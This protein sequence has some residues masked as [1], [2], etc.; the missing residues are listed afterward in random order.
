M[1]FIIAEKL[2][3][4][5]YQMPSYCT[6]YHLFLEQFKLKSLNLHIHDLFVNNKT[7]YNNTPTDFR[8]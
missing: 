5:R 3:I 8:L 4:N 2:V 1:H 6:F 7:G